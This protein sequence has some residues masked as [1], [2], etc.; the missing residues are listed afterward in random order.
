MA[1][2]KQYPL[3]GKQLLP[4]NQRIIQVNINSFIFD[5]INEF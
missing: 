3:I 5:K 1:N 4:H 2:V